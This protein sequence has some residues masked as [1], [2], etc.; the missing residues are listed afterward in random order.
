M[1]E[2]KRSKKATEAAKLPKGNMMNNQ[3]LGSYSVTSI[4]VLFY[5]NMGF[6]FE[7]NRHIRTKIARYL[8]AVDN[9]QFTVEEFCSAVFE[10]MEEMCAMSFK[11]SEATLTERYSRPW[12]G[13]QSPAAKVTANIG[14]HLIQTRFLKRNPEAAESPVFCEFVRKV[15]LDPRFGTGRLPFI[16]NLLPMTKN[17]EGIDFIPFLEDDLYAG[18][19]ISAL[20]KLKDGRFAKEAEKVLKTNP[21]NPFRRQIKRYIRLYKENE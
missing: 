9:D 5:G 8:Y 12:I 21:K 6:S 10:L 2:V 1:Q 17:S 7:Q 14:S 16:E 20:L 15:I 11:I 19:T 18:P 3:E 4:D 13:K